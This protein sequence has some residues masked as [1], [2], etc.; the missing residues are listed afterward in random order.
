[1]GMTDQ[2]LSAF[3]AL[4][5]TTLQNLAVSAQHLLT[6]RWPERV[7]FWMQL[8]ESTSSAPPPL[9]VRL[10]G[11]QMMAAEACAPVPGTC[12]TLP[13]HKLPG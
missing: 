10:I 8:L 5:L 12:A 9:D 3:E 1:L 7:G 2:T 11:L 6:P 4:T 13:R